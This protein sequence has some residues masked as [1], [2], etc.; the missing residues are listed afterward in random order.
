MK[1][2][3]AVLAIFIL[4]AVEAQGLAAAPGPA[5]APS[6]AVS[7]RGFALGVF[8]GEP[9]GI[10]ARWGF[11]GEQSL[12]G[13][14]AW[15]FSTADG[16]SANFIFQGNYLLEIPGILAIQGEHF[17]LY[18]GLGAETRLGSDFNLSLR[19]PGGVIYRFRTVPIEACL[20]LGI[21]LELYPSTV[22]VGSGGLGLRYRF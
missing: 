16:H 20:E 21:G 6:E 1:F 4:V 7:P 11:A 22:L 5:A 13:K 10:S 9:T 19:V 8:L 2:R 15:S 14:A 17:P 3:V 18:F 12:E